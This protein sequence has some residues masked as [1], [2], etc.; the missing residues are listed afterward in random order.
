MRPKLRLCG[1]SA[2]FDQPDGT[3][4]KQALYSNSL[5]WLLCASERIRGLIL[6]RTAAGNRSY[7]AAEQPGTSRQRREVHLAGCLH[8][9]W[10]RRPIERP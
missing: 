4:N 3:S 8:H 1:G 7:L 10:R 5:C 2:S 9:A 6:W